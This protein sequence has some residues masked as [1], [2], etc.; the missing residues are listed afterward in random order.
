M[1]D[2]FGVW[3][4]ARQVRRSL[5]SFAGKRVGDI[6]CGYQA[7]FAR[8]LLD[9]VGRLV[10]LDVALAPDLRQHPKVA[11]IEGRLPEAMVAVPDQSL[12]VVVCNSVLEHL[13]DPLTALCEFHRVLVPA[14]TL[15]VNVPSWR[16]KHFL[17]VS[18]FR[19]GTS[20]AEEVDDHKM[21]YDPQDLW[22]LLVRSGFPPHSIR[23]FRHKFGLNTFARCRKPAA[24]GA[25]E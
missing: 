8:T 1:V 18:A 3:L 10:L 17:E 20:P 23:C 15:L 5:S 24:A 21:Y 19:F 25:V 22:P 9:D 13:W 4:S 7:S 6:G 11:A 14:G 16:G 12:E 2:R